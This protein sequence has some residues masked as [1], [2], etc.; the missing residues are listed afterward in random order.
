MEPTVCFVSASRQ[1]VFFAELLDVL[2]DALSAHGLA[3]ERA[4]DYF[5]ALRDGLV[6]VFVPHELMP[7]MMADAHPSDL[8]LRRSIAICTEQP[9]TQWFEQT[10]QIAARTGHC[11][12]INRLGVTALGK[13]GIDAGFLQLGYTP[14]W[15]RWHGQH[16][17]ARPVDLAFLAGATP[18]RLTAI[19]RSATHIAGR[20]TE[21][22]MPEA[23]VPHDAE[24][25][26]FLS[27]DDKWRLLSRSKLLLNVH[28]GELGYFEWQRAI[29][30]IANGCVLLSEHSLGFAPLVPGEHFVSVSYDSL[31]V[32]LGALLDDDDRLARMRADAYEFIRDEHPLSRSI[33]VLA[34]AIDEV[35]AVPIAVDRGRSREIAP[36]P[37]PL[38]YPPP[39]Y[40]RVM[41][42]RTDVDVL[43]MATKQLLL[44]QREMRKTLRNI[45]ISVA[46]GGPD[47]D[48]TETFGPTGSAPRVS[49]VVTVYNYAALV[50]K[51]IESVAASDFADYEM[52]IV[53]DASSD[54]SGERI[55]T[56][57]AWA[58]WVPARLVTRSRNGGL[59]EARNLGTQL[60]AGELVFI[61][62]ADNMVYPHTLRRLVE[63]LDEAPDASFAYGII[64]QFGVDG[65]SGLVSYLGW[66]P[67]RLRY[68]NFV[69]AMAMMRRAPLLE[70]GGYVTDPRLHGWEDFALWCAFADRGWRGV[71]VPEIVARYRVAPH[72][73]IS[74]TNIDTSVAWS[75][76][77]DRFAFL[78]A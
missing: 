1:N 21:L 5:P 34:E 8:Q 13:R 19:A 70:L 74:I 64:E 22:H 24:S 49:V 27:G 32:A 41:S 47:E 43:R 50:T 48:V 67:Q 2:A 7:L 20:R 15:D 72:S 73:M 69:D 17:S 71:R 37:K 16:D 14:R 78:S 61:L 54:D 9:G 53:D 66:D 3:V 52:V 68:G 28:R 65:P 30:A 56:A 46:G 26:H 39:E 29:E 75:L 18:R 33:V 77:L 60:A 31:D 12:D 40:Q 10:A 63:V 42:A 76:L 62:D 51:A 57:L 38:P 25:E 59:A 36:R 6:Y 23:L 11:V 45:E 35:A 58:P 55:R 44:D 4:V